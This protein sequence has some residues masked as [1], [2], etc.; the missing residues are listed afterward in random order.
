VI[1]AFSATVPAGDL[2]DIGG[3]KA[4]LLKIG[5]IEPESSAIVV[6]RDGTIAPS[7]N[8]ALVLPYD[9]EIES[10]FTENSSEAPV[11]SDLTMN[12]TVYAAESGSG[13]FTPLNATKT[14]SG[15]LAAG[16]P[17]GSMAYASTSGISAY[18]PKGY[19]LLI[20]GEAYSP[21]PVGAYRFNGSLGLKIL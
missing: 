21:Q 11:Y 4:A 2:S 18:V 9:V 3:V 6:A 1:L 8:Y 10:V 17:A 19:R 7:G 12:V 14:R 13:T 5:A 20:V 15:A 16:S